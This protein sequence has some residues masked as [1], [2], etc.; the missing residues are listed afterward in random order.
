MSDGAMNPNAAVVA[1]EQ[2]TA[3]L[4]DAVDKERGLPA[5]ERSLQ[6]WSDE[7]HELRTLLAAGALMSRTVKLPELAGSVK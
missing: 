4:R 7:I 5:D 1:L 3:A 6:R 2:A